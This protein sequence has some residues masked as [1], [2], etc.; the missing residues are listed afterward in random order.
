MVRD[1]GSTSLVSI[2]VS[3]ANL[4]YQLN[5]SCM[6]PLS[7]KLKI[8]VAAAIVNAQSSF[9]PISFS[10][11]R[12]VGIAPT[13]GEAARSSVDILLKPN[14]REC[15]AGR[16]LRAFAFVTSMILHK[17]ASMLLLL[18]VAPLYCSYICIISS[19][20]LLFVVAYRRVFL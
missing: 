9:F 17:R 19:E 15:L 3:V 2:G 12:S 18:S 6:W 7:I 10:N 8:R 20:I 5:T 4:L 14:G 11:Y 13:E 1:W 16:I